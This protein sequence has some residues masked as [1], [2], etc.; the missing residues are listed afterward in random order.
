MSGKIRTFTSRLLFSIFSYRLY[1]PG[2]ITGLSRSLL[3]AGMLL[4]LMFNDINFIIP[5]HYLNTLDLHSLRYKCNF[6]L[7]LDS[8][9]LTE[10][11]IIAIVIL[12]FILSGYFIKITSLLQF[13]ITASFFMLRPPFFAEGDSV[14]MLL[15]L[16]LVPV[17]LCDDRKNH[18]MEDIATTKLNAS[19]QKI[20]LFIIKLQVAFIY[21]DSVYSKLQLKEWRSGTVIYYWF[22]HNFFGLHPIVSNTVEPVLR[23]FPIINLVIAWGSLLFEALLFTGL[24]LSSGYKLLL[25]KYG[26]IFHLCIML[27]HGYASFFFVMSAALFMYLYPTNNLPATNTFYNEKQQF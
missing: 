13:W 20:F 19:I 25:L 9:H 2:Q 26:L 23:T 24:F 10:L 16:L 18:W 21:F 14:N 7:L 27:I 5:R 11:Q 1:T 3:A 12:L 15:S 22:T 4:T 17:C 8:L 6:F